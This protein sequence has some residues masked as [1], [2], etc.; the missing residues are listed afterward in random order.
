MKNPNLILQKILL[1]LVSGNRG[2]GYGSRSPKPLQE[3]VDGMEFEA[4]HNMV[5]KEVLY[6]NTFTE[7]EKKLAVCI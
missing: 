4:A 3:E 2:S 5:K 7:A 6:K 1:D